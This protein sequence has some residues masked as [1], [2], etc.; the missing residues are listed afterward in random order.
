MPWIAILT[1]IQE[2]EDV[3]FR[4]IYSG[5]SASVK[6]I[7]GGDLEWLELGS[8]ISTF[9]RINQQRATT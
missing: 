9:A 8:K 2:F 5:N 7:V 3:A 1:S 6:L 4:V